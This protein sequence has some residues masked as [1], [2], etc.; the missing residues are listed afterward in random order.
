MNRPY[1][2]FSLPSSAG[3]VALT[4]LPRSL[5]STTTHFDSGNTSSSLT[6]TV[7]TFFDLAPRPPQARARATSTASD[8]HQASRPRREAERVIG[9]N[10]W[11]REV[12]ERRRRRATE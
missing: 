10:S 2:F 11:Q 3:S 8:E 7:P 9:G 4:V 12:V 1:V 6:L 5:T